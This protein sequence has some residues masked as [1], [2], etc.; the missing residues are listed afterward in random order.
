MLAPNSRLLL[1]DRLR[2]PTGFTVDAAIG[3]TYTL[4]LDALLIPPAAWAVHS[5]G[6]RFDRADPILLANS[7]RLFAE[8]TIVF[9]QAGA[10]APFAMGSELL[11]SLLDEMVF[12]VPVG[13]GETFHP[14]VWIIRF[15]NDD[16]ETALR[17][18]VGSRNLS[19]E[20]TWDA[21]ISLDATN[22]GDGTASG[23]PLAAMLR[24]LE[25]RSIFGL[26]DDRRAMLLSVATDLDQAQFQQPDGCTSAEFFWWRRGMPTASLL[27]TRCDRRLVISPFLS[28]PGLARLPTPEAGGRSV[29]VSRAASLSGELAA[30]FEPYVL[31]TDLAGIDSG[32]EARLGNDLHAK[33]FAFDADGTSIL[34]IGSAN[35][36]AAAFSMNDEVVVRLRGE[37]SAIGVEAL[38][39]T[40]SGSKD[41]SDDIELLDLLEPWFDLGAVE[42]DTDDG[43]FF[44]EAIRSVACLAVCGTCIESADDRYALTLSLSAPVGELGGID[45]DFRLLSQST[46]LPD[47]FASGHEVTIDVDLG[48]ATRFIAARF[49][50]PA[51]LVEA[52]TVVLVADVQMPAGRSR[53]VLR[54][55]LTDRE[56]FARFL[57]Y[58][59][60]STQDTVGEI[61]MSDVISDIPSPRRRSRS[62]V[63]EEGPILEQLL[64]L[65]AASPGDLRQLDA[66]IKE[67]AEDRNLLPDGFG[68]LWE[69]ISPLI[70][71]EATP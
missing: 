32:E 65:L 31:R 21:L 42:T 61:G 23:A 68:E 47:E 43:R 17:V 56:R 14:K 6:D 44:E 36:T 38:L 52:T 30:G 16:G 64:R 4:G 12:P 62:R 7:L 63:F 39:G 45:V 1:L 41:A 5:I 24:S 69:A 71:Q 9:H 48:D 27:P 19:F 58:L 51:G 3:T 33:V 50:D 8:R 26:P 54:S 57:R 11:A 25:T 13:K 67:F 34:I 49:S 59:L 2:P 46:S 70:P 66:V 15:R 53:R 60:E 37:T 22:A 10:T 55:L 28:G 35:A 29:L 40:A 20:S 18:L